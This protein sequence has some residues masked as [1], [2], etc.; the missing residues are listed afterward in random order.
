MLPFSQWFPTLSTSLGIMAKTEGQIEYANKQAFG[1]SQD[2]LKG[3]SIFEFVE[4]E[5]VEEFKQVI[6]EVVQSQE[7]KELVVIDRG[8]WIRLR[9]GPVIKGNQV[10][11]LVLNSVV[12]SEQ[13]EFQEKL[14]HSEKM[15]RSILDESPEGIMLI[16]ETG[17]VVEWNRAQE[18]IFGLKSDKAIGKKVWD[19][20]YM[21]TPNLDSSRDIET[22]K[23]S[24][25]KVFVATEHTNAIYQKVASPSK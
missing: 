9:I 3:R 7:R 11:S 21:F 1:L 2:E 22:I 19:I 18:E 20:Q 25:Q 14:S 17:T 5:Y 13:I 10:V 4:R 23:N 6:S 8:H 12:I 15:L 24:Y 16:D